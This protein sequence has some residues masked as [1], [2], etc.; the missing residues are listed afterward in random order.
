MAHSL[1]LHL[2]LLALIPIQQCGGRLI[3]LEDIVY[4]FLLL[5]CTN[6]ERLVTYDVFGDNKTRG[7]HPEQDLFKNPPVTIEVGPVTYGKAQVQS[8][9]ISAVYVQIFHNN[10]TDEVGK[11]QISEQVE[12]EDEYIWTV[13][14]GLEFTAKL[15]FSVNVPLVYQ[16]SSE[17]STSVKSST[18]STTVETRTTKQ[19][20]KQEVEI[21][22]LSTIEAK[23]FVNEAKVVVPWVLDITLKGNVAAL[24]EKPGNQLAWK[25]I[26][27]SEVKHEHITRNGSSVSLQA[28][29]QFTATVAQSYHLSTSEKK[30]TQ[31]TARLAK[32]IFEQVDE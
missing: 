16:F 9:Q 5:N 8:L 15:T 29:G 2:L 31:R 28:S 23:W 12:H 10:Q 21:P 3:D 11:A 32:F 6:N 26:S 22:P 17:F 27:V 30:L 19:W 25:Y 1:Q 20:I 7:P 14:K 4:K 13:D 24:F 18:G